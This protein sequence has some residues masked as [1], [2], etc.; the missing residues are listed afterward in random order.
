LNV[1][2]MAGNEI[3]GYVTRSV[4]S[5]LCAGRTAHPILEGE[6]L[7]QDRFGSDAFDST[8]MRLEAE[9]GNPALVQMKSIRLE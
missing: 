5:W 3:L 9:S 8:K 7:P 4:V 1:N 2:A 6:L